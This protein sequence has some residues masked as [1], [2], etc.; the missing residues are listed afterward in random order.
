M[1]SFEIQME[2][3]RTSNGIMTINFW[4]A[5][6]L[7]A[8]RLYLC[9]QENTGI[10]LKTKRKAVDSCSGVCKMVFTS[11]GCTAWNEATLTKRL[12]Q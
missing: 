8:S 4:K 11:M 10:G 5:L 12:S 3:H 7:M 6:V 2:N 9:V 1:S